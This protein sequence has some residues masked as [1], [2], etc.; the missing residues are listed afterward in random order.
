MIRVFSLRRAALPAA[1]GFAL[2]TALLLWWMQPTPGWTDGA[3]DPWVPPIAGST[4]TLVRA[5][6][7]PAAR[8]GHA[9]RAP[10]ELGEVTVVAAPPG[11]AARA[12]VTRDGLPVSTFADGPVTVLAAVGD[13]IAV[14]SPAPR[15]R[16]RI[17][18]VGPEIV[19]PHRPGWLPLRAGVTVLGRVGRSAGQGQTVR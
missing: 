16:V 13:T 2:A 5:A 17:L 3:V 10:V 19:F 4:G 1:A 8:A 11:L 14:E 18:A 6:G 12:V 7:V 9:L 15:V